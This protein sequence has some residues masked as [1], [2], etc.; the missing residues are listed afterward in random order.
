MFVVFLVVMKRF[1]MSVFFFSSRRRLTRWNCDWSSDVCSSD[2]MD[3]E[4]ADVVLTRG[5]DSL[6][7]PALR[8]PLGDQPPYGVKQECAGAAGRIEHSLAQRRIDR[9]S[10]D[11]RRQPVRGVVL[12][13]V[14]PLVGI[15]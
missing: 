5:Q 9:R 15:D 3:I 12:T 4:A 14:V 1:V 10:H 13:E 6:R 8:P 11:P 2:L 7:R